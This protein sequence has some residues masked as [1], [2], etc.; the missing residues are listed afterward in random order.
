MAVTMLSTIESKAHKMAMKRL[1]LND[2]ERGQAFSIGCE[3]YQ[4][5]KKK[6]TKYPK[7]F[8]AHTEHGMFRVT[9]QKI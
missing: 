8:E 7:I 2:R 5:L 1:N 9:I 4:H 6:S 3:L